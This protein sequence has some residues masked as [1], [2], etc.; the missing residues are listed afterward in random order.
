MGRLKMLRDA[1]HKPVIYDEVGYEGNLMQR[2]VHLLTHRILSGGQ[3][4]ER[5]EAKVPNG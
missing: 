5:L 4:A 2:W 1:Y 3:K